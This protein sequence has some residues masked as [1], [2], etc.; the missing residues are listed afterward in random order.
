METNRN[1]FYKYFLVY[2]IKIWDKIPAGWIVGF[3]AILFYIRAMLNYK[4]INN[5]D[6]LAKEKHKDPNYFISKFLSK[7]KRISK[8]YSTFWW[9]DY[10]DGCKNFAKGSNA[11][12][13]VLLF[14]IFIIFSMILSK[15][16]G[17]EIYSITFG[18]PIPSR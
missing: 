18:L 1:L 9:Y 6:K 15:T 2:F 3:F 11:I 8:E 7:A 17:N 13:V 16:S 4:I 14:L 5:I 12:S 10:P